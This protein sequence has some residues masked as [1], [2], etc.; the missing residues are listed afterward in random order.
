MYNSYFESRCFLIH[1]HQLLFNYSLAIS[2]EKNSALFGYHLANI[3]QPSTCCKLF[4]KLL[5]RLCADIPLIYRLWFSIYGLQ[6][7]DNDL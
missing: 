3:F 6:T 4:E 5:K 1:T 2:D 7:T